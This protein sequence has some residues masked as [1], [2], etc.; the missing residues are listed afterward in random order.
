MFVVDLDSGILI[1]D[2][3]AVLVVGI[4]VGQKSGNS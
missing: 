4:D 3:K 2:N 1:S